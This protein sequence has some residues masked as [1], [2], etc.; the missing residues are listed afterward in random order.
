MDT[1]VL[2]LS[3]L[4]VSVVGLGCNNFGRPGTATESKEGTA[5]VVDAAIEAG[6]TFFDT[7]D[8]Y[9]AEYGLSETRIGEVLGRK[10][11]QVVLATKF[12]HVDFASPIPGKRGSR[13]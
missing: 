2:G 12:G 3:S 13:E 11:D 9:G 1:R 8:I 10:R 5:A 4:T 7:A 6:G